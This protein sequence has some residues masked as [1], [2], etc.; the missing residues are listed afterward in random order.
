[1]LSARR[2]LL[3][4]ALA[5]AVILALAAWLRLAGLD[6]TSLFGDEAVYSGQAAALAG[7]AAAANN[8]GVFLAHPVLFQLLLGLGF[9]GGLPVDG[10]RVL[11]AL[12]GVGSV[13]L[14][15]S[16]GRFVGGRLLGLAAAVLLAVLAYDAYLSRLVLLDGPAAF[17]VGCSLYAFLRAERERSG[18]WLAA[19]AATLALAVLVKETAVLILPA[20][21][22]VAAVEPRLRLG[23]RAW[24]LAAASFVA[25]IAAF[26]LSLLLGGGIGPTLTYLHYQLGRHAQSAFLT[27]F[28]LI[29]P[30]VGWPFV[31]LAVIGL[32]VALQRGGS[33]RIIAIWAIVPGAI[34]QAWGLRELQLPML[35]VLQ[36]TL[37]C[38]I[39]HGAATL[40]A[41]RRAGAAIWRGEIAGVLAVGLVVAV[42]LSL[43]PATLRSTSLPD[44]QPAQSGLGEASLWLRDHAEPGDGVFVSTAYKSSVV[45]YY[46]GRP[47]YGFS[48]ARRRDPVYRDAG[49]VE[50]FWRAG[51]IQWVVLDRDSQGR[52]TASPDGSAPYARLLRLLDAFPH[53]LAFVVPGPTPDSWLAQVYR[54]T[55]TPGVGPTVAAPDVV[56]RGDGRI[57]ALSYAFCVALG[58]GIVLLAHR[59]A[60]RTVG[61]DSRPDHLA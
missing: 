7:D 28:H 55:P 44:G 37:L 31:V 25:V 6:R 52:A 8:F 38:A 42:G 2:T 10:G 11:T 1:V 27:Y 48:A 57:V 26:P 15:W 24:L 23:H 18:T 61:D 4:E 35:V 51:G 12:F 49:D 47:S 56:G 36:G 34:L 19:A 20:V 3:V 33:R 40:L 46:S 58:A 22:I 59:S 9:A 32:V 29:D 60:S 30:Y 14:A 17:V 54:L 50:A 43:L 13:V 53:E 41:R 5:L 21:A 16:I 45:A 39:G